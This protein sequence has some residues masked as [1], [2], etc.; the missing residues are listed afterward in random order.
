MV[1]EYE[2]FCKTIDAAYKHATEHNDISV[3]LNEAIF[4]LG[5]FQAFKQSGC[6]DNICG[7]LVYFAMK[8]IRGKQ[9]PEQ[10]TAG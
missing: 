7:L 3:D 8:Y 1:K 10:D 6:P 5:T 4:K 9:A 2:G